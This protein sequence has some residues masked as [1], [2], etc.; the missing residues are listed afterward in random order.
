MA[1][2]AYTK[3][4]L[5]NTILGIKCPS[6]KKFKVAQV[7]S[8]FKVNFNKGDKKPQLL[9]VLL[10]LSKTISMKEQTAITSWLNNPNATLSQLADVVSE[11]RSQRPDSE[12]APPGSS[13]AP[14]TDGTNQQYDPN[15]KE[16]A[17]CTDKLSAECFPDKL[18]SSCDHKSNICKSCLKRY[19]D[20]YIREHPY[21]QVQ[22]PECKQILLE[23]AVR[24]FAS[25]D[26]FERW[27]LL[28][29]RSV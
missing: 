5:P 25:E 8:Y 6:H 27:V 9:A 15:G 21:Q 19:I 13:S 2:S 3:A 17:A 7:L 28:A 23:D 14:T 16:C 20:I 4:G 29:R 1:P 22:C 24:E 18:S 11:A 12:S 26:S 10:T